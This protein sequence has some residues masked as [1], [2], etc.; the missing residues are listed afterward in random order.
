MERGW[1]RESFAFAIALQNLVWGVAQPFSG[2][3]A[4]KFGT[5][6]VVHAGAALYAAGLVVMALAD[7]PWGF[8]AARRGR[9]DRESAN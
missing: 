1:G 4:D 2:M 3:L 9:R 8:G 5:G 7:T 6:R